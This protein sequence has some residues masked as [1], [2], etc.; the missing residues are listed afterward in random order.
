MKRIEKFV[1][2]LTSIFWLVQ[3]VVACVQLHFIIQPTHSHSK[4]IL[5]VNSIARHHILAS[6]DSV[7]TTI[8]LCYLPA[9]TIMRV[10]ALH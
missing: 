9:S 10:M 4:F 5:D 3:A 7:Y 8:L 6:F 2:S 1:S